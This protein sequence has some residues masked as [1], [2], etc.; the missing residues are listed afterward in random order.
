ME[1]TKWAH[2]GYMDGI[3]GADPDPKL[4][5]SNEYSDAWLIGVADREA[6]IEPSK[7]MDTLDRSELPVKRGDTVT[8]PKGTKIKTIYHG[9]RLAGR[10]YKVELHNVYP[11]IPAHFEYGSRELRRPVPAKVIWPGTGGYWS[12]ANL[13]DVAI[14]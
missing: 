12:E 10:T 1:H 9:E 13:E 8:I 6:G 3:T 11:A 7:Y 2:K 4:E 14:R 5:K